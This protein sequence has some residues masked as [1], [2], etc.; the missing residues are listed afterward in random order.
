MEVRV[1][2]PYTNT[3]Q[4]FIRMIAFLATFITLGLVVV[5]PLGVT[6]NPT[7]FLVSLFIAFAVSTVVSRMFHVLPEW[8]RLVLLRLGEFV[9]VKG[10]GF[11]VI[12]PFIY[13]VASIVDTR[14]I[15]YKV[16]AT[17]TLTQDNV[18]TKVT[19]AIEFEVED[20][21]K[22]VI[23]VKDYLSS[24]IWLSTEA[25]KNTIGSLDLKELLSNREEIAKQ[26]KSQIDAD[27]TIYGI[28]VRAVRI[29]DVDT[30]PE[31]VQELAVI[32]RARR[33]AQAK[34]IQADAEVAVANK[35][36]EA[37]KILAKQDGGFHLR[38]IQNLAEMSKEE[39]SMIIV[40]PYE[41]SS[42][43]DIAHA[44]VATAVK[45]VSPKAV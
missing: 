25:L 9:G 1:A 14:I 40:Y 7:L 43:K 33:A 2:S 28:N 4:G 44:S 39:S 45:K 26:L 35:M 34:Q 32:A 8:E 22:A 42:G 15:T 24:V 30:P 36:A 12:P 10:P 41:S 37:S 17:A 3:A 29:T 23:D 11:F 5:L 13:S 31:L 21:K 6:T 18:P 27:A 20:P 16:E 38:E 19:A